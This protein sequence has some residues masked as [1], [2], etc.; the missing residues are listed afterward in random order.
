MQI[1]FPP[2]RRTMSGRKNPAD[3]RGD[4]PLLLPPADARQLTAY[5]GSLMA[6]GGR[7][8]EKRPLPGSSDTKAA[9]PGPA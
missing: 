4:A 1:R 5:A 9:A 7:S 8:R 3:I 2:N 6:V